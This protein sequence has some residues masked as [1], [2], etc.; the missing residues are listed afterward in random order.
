MTVFLFFQSIVCPADETAQDERGS[1]AFRA[2]Q[3]LVRTGLHAARLAPQPLRKL[4]QP[5]LVELGLR[6]LCPPGSLRGD[7]VGFRPAQGCGNARGQSTFPT[8]E[9]RPDGIDH[10]LLRGQIAVLCFHVKSRYAR[11]AL[12]EQPERVRHRAIAAQR[13]AVGIQRVQPLHVA[14]VAKGR[15]IRAGHVDHPVGIDDRQEPVVVGPRRIQMPLRNGQHR[16]V[17]GRLVERRHLRHHVQG[18]QHLI[19]A[20]EGIQNPEQLREAV[21]GVKGR[22]LAHHILRPS[23][24]LWDRK[25]AVVRRPEHD[26]ASAA[27]PVTLF[28]P[29]PLPAV[30]IFLDES[31]RDKSAHGV[32]DEVHGLIAEAV[33]DLHLQ[34]VG[35]RVEVLAP[36]VPEGQD[37]P[38]RREAQEHR[39]V[40]F[41]ENA[42]RAHREK[43]APFRAQPQP[44]HATEEDAQD[45]NP[46][47]LRPAILAGPGELAAHDP[48]GDD[49]VAL[50]HGARAPAGER[51]LNREAAQPFV[52]RVAEVHPQRTLLFARGAV[53][54]SGEFRGI[55]R[56]E[57]GDEGAFVHGSGVRNGS[58]KSAAHRPAVGPACGKCSRRACMIAPESARR[59]VSRQQRV[60]PQFGLRL[61]RHCRALR[62]HPPCRSSSPASSF[63]ATCSARF[64]SGC[65]S[66]KLVEWTSEISAAETSERRTS[67]A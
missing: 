39:A 7:R 42:R 29:H 6:A 57:T 55:R 16:A 24:D 52:S 22:E 62:A 26:Q 1:L 28:V 67:G 63:S 59:L 4:A 45:V 19:R 14:D 32:A 50:L 36:V 20:R 27:F 58:A 11:T 15:L 51:W 35:R 30:G 37:V 5:R 12:A 49:D 47:R 2:A 65:S 41:F 31:A 23:H 44:A 9:Q 17:G 13:L 54:Q 3:R 43:I 10:P 64:H 66:Q 8:R 33:F 25:G 38:L 21:A 46:E 60:K 61:V 34:R 40:V 48:V 53:E 18:G 56:F